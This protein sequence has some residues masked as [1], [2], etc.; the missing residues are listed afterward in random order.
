MPNGKK[1]GEKMC[2]RAACLWHRPV[3]LVSKKAIENSSNW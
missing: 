3:D 2:G 1:I